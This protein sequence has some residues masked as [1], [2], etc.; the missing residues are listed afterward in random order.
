MKKEPHQSQLRINPRERIATKADGSRIPVVD[1]K[2]DVLIQP[3][4][5]DIKK[6]IR[7]DHANC[8]YCLACRRMYGSDLV[9]VTRTLAYVELKA[10]GGK[11]E[12]QRF[13]LRDP[14]KVKIRQFDSGL[15]PTP[16][17]V[18]F[19]APRNSETLDAKTAGWKRWKKKQKDKKTA[20]VKG[21][22]MGA[23]KSKP[24]PLFS[25]LRDSAYGM[26]QFKQKTA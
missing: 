6:G 24:H 25:V 9:W 20:Y 14:A 16:E 26:F 1:A 18:V 17:A 23:I 15:G 7:G 21:E 22:K 11:P 5:E 3:A 4:E 8:M 13:I 12:L 19:A 2:Y 10:K